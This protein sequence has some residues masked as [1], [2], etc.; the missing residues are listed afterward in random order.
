M[1]KAR[2]HKIIYI[3]MQLTSVYSPPSINCCVHSWMHCVINQE[4]RRREIK[5]HN[6]QRSVQESAILY[7]I[8]DRILLQI[9]DEVKDHWYIPLIFTQFSK[10]TYNYSGVS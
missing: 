1:K 7:L 9:S 10:P 4:M 5:S 6:N 3:G 2:C 8:K